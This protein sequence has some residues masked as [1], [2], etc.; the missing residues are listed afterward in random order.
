MDNATKKRLPKGQTLTNQWP[1][2]HEGT[3]PGTDLK[4]WTF[5][6]FG[7]VGKEVTLT[8]DEL[9][10]LPKETYRS[11][12]HCVTTWSRYDNLWEGVPFTAVMALTSVE[13][14][15]QYVLIHAEQGYM[16]NLPLAE[17]L[18]PGVLFA[19]AHDGKPLSPE[20][21]YPLRLVVPHLYFWKSAKWVRGIEFMERNRPGFWEERGYHLIGDPWGIDEQ[22]PDGQ[23]FRDDPGWYGSGSDSSWEEW[24]RRM[25][26]VR[27]RRT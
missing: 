7:R 15:A 24:E 20:H 3:V 1:V 8:W 23:R 6:V 26:S 14:A 19:Y 17:L 13:L 10:A 22:N 9:M 4:T 25:E 11:D 16:T 2:L 12:I 5:R 27:G 18:K 21:G